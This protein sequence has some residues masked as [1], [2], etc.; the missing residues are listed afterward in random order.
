MCPNVFLVYTAHIWLGVGPD[1]AEMR[2]N[3]FV[4]IIRMVQIPPVD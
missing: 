3:G 2:I 1:F 4:R